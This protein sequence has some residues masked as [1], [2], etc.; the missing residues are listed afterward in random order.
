MKKNLIKLSLV[1][2]ALSTSN[3]Y[4]GQIVS[5]QSEGFTPNKQYAY[6]GWNLENVN[7]KIV[8]L[9]DPHYNIGDFDE[10]TGAYSQLTYGMSFES[11]ITSNGTVLGRLIG[12]QWPL[13]EPAG[14]KII[15]GDTGVKNGQPENCLMATTFLAGGYLDSASPRSNTC[16]GPFK[17]HKRF[18][19]EMM[20]ST[21]VSDGTYGKPIDLVFN[22]VEGDTSTKRYRIIQKLN[23]HT[24]KR[25]DGYKLEVLDDAKM[26][27]MALTL[28][29]GYGENDGK[30]I[31]GIDQMAN[32][33][34]GL[35]GPIDSHFG[36]E[37]FFDTK[38][39]YYPVGLSNGNT[40]IS[41]I[42]PMRGGNYQQLFGNWMPSKWHPMGIYYDDGNLGTEDELLAF[43]GD[44]LKTGVNGWHKGQAD[45]WAK[46]TEE[47]ERV[48]TAGG[49]YYIAGIEDSV[50]L[51]L[52]Y[53][54]NIGDNEEIGSTF[55]I[56]ITPHFAPSSEQS[57]PSFAK[58]APKPTHPG[59][60]RDNPNEGKGSVPAYDS[61]SLLVMIF[62]FLGI[63]ALIARRKLV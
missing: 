48:W 28:S 34:H 21:Y 52:N 8:D 13:G 63:G 37:G 16:S 32:M 10:S 53:I 4:A 46:L 18:K 30:N 27:N 14:I 5:N 38:R 51:G 59:S 1:I 11:D 61:M 7:V 2:A 42:G 23:N 47:E 55:T 29:L 25:L 33:P 44:P 3:I 36:A 9:K 43:W 62:G 49:Q 58:D 40:V 39:S 31:W 12:K 24:G 15:N 57:T 60:E 50:N 22:L 35:F 26:P 20:Q 56:R 17:S 6:G 41:Y 45:N 54:V 19:I